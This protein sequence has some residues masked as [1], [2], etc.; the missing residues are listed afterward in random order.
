M[1]TFYNNATANL[2]KADTL[3]SKII[4]CSALNL[5]TG[6]RQNKILKAFMFPNPSTGKFTLSISEAYQNATIMVYDMIGN[7]VD[8]RTVSGLNT[9]SLDYTSLPKGGYLLQFN[10]EKGNY[11]SRIIFE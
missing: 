5:T 11:S 8:V 1:S 3:Q 9:I 6:I 7:V 10:T 4:D 2:S